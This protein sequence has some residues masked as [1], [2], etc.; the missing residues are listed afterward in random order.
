MYENDRSVTTPAAARQIC[1]KRRSLL[2]LTPLAAVA[3]GMPA[4]TLGQLQQEQGLIAACMEVIALEHHIWKIL[5]T[6]FSEHQ[7]RDLDTAQ[8][9]FSARQNHLIKEIC[10]A[11]AY[12][13]DGCRAK[14]KA[15]AAWAPDMME[16]ATGPGASRFLNE[17]LD[18]LMV[19][20]ILRD[21][22]AGGLA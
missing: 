6:R 22:V 7:D 1:A 13:L 4:T 8:A 2:A 12:T 20:S 14:A 18:E 15:L 21:L 5:P 19:A 3:A 9:P 10:I 11:K 17:R 16:D